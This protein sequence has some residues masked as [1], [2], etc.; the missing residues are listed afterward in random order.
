MYHYSQGHDQACRRI[1]MMM[2]TLLGYDRYFSLSPNIIMMIE[3][4]KMMVM[5]LV[6]TPVSL[7]SRS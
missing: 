3:K 7:S 6:A 2:I 1:M 5:R 4:M